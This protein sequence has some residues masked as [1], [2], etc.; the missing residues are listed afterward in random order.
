VPCTKKGRS[1]RFA[2]VAWGAIAIATGQTPDGGWH[3]S[4][5]N[6]FSLMGS[7]VFCLKTINSKEGSKDETS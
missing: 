7:Q 2:A 3:C 4:C 1:G 5:W 6:G